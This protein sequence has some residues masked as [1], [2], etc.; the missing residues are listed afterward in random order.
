MTVD[1]LTLEEEERP[2]LRAK[3]SRAFAWSFLNT[4]VSRLGTLAVGVVLARMLGPEEFGSFAIAMTALIAVLSLNELGVSLAIVR[5][6]DDPRTIAASVTSISML[7]STVFFLLMWLLAPWFASTMGDPSAAWVV[8]V[9]S[10]AVLLNGLSA[11]PAAMM[12]RQFLQRRRTI[13]DQVNTWLGAALSLGLAFLDVGAMSLAI[14]RVA[15]SLVAAVLFLVLSPIPVRF[16]W[17]RRQ[18]RRLLGFGLPLAG[19]SAIAYAAGYAD[20]LVVG[21]TLGATSLGFY[22]LA[23]NLA[24]WPVSIFSQPL[25]SVAPAVFARMQH[26][27]VQMA[28]AFYALLAVLAAVALPIC[29]VLAGA[30]R[31][32][33]RLVYG[34][35]WMPS[36]DIL[37]WLGLLAGFRIMFE[38]A[39]DYLVVV[40][41]GRGILLAQL[42]WVVIAVPVLLVSSSL[43]GL[44]G[45][46]LSQLLTAAI[47]MSAVYL[48]LLR[49]TGL[50]PMR[51][52]HSVRISAVAAAA[53]FGLC[54][55]VDHFVAAHLIATLFSG[56]CAV[57]LVG[58]AL[59]LQRRRLVAAGI[60][61]RRKTIV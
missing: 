9:M 47:V 18:V 57:G 17:D 15:G 53:A 38:L 14:G 32:L 49:R 50:S 20:Q 5:W 35:E 45:V 60:T 33:I 24:S 25:R 31:P 27:R 13:I 4:A 56:I 54:Q 3:A 34:V 51:C 29:A 41:A 2:H 1:Q 8:R 30:S 40:G 43:G 55:L 26:D 16:G 12:Q 22:V 61:I 11:T 58:A 28:G 10:A 59:L 19:A 52:V 6:R 48:A 37:A 36:A 23:F 46:A 44:R 21:S 7:S 39:Y 42:A